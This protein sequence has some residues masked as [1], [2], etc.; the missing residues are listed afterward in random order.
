MTFTHGQSESVLKLL[1]L[2]GLRDKAV[3]NLTFRFAVDEISIAVVELAIDE[4]VVLAMAEVLE[5]AKAAGELDLMEICEEP[6]V[7]FAEEADVHAN[8]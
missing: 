2:L 8:A 3:M 4:E 7:A 5:K 6:A 1:E